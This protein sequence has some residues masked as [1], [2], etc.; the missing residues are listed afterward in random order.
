MQITRTSP[1]SG[2]ENTMEINISHAQ[3]AAWENGML[4]Q[5]AMPNLTA[6]EREFIMTGITDQEWNELSPEEDKEDDDEHH[7]TEKA[8]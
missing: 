8:F 4:I 6:A 2:K 7:E 5:R 3:L 1:I